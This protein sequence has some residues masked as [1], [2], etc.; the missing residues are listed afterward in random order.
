MRA[1]STLLEEGWAVLTSSSGSTR[2]L[3]LLHASTKCS[4]MSLT[5]GLRGKEATEPVCTL[6]QSSRSFCF[7]AA[8]ICTLTCMQQGCVQAL[9]LTTRMGLC[10]L[11]LDSVDLVT[12]EDTAAPCLCPLSDFLPPSAL[13]LPFPSAASAFPPN[14][15]VP[16]SPSFVN[17]TFASSFLYFVSPVASTHSSHFLFQPCTSREGAFVMRVIDVSTAH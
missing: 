16:P 2:S 13:D 10:T 12:F 1:E 7:S 11:S 17:S 5:L 4:R 14:S 9:S 3:L 15:L 6:S 8:G